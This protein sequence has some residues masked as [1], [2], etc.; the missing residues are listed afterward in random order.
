LDSGSS[1]EEDIDPD[2]EDSY[3]EKSLEEIKE[4]IGGMGHQS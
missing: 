4:D 2:E 1:P 3:G